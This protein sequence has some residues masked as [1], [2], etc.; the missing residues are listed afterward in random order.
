MKFT[1]EN[2]STDKPQVNILVVDD[3]EENLFSMEAILEK[4]GY[5]IVKA[6]SGK[7]ALKILL[8][9]YDFSLILM[10]VQM[11]ELNGFETAGLIY[12]RER[13]K[14]I[15]IIF[16]TANDHG[17]D[18]L[19]KGYR[20][21][22]V[23]YLF[24]PIDPDLLRAKV[25]VFADLY[26][27]KYQLMMQEQKLIMANKKLEQEVE[28]KRISEEKIQVLNNQLVENIDHLKAINEDLE[29][30]AYVASHDLQ[31]PLRKIIL[32]GDRLSGK[33]SDALGAEGVDYLNRMVK[34]TGRMQELIKNILSFSRATTNIDDLE[35]TDINVILDNIISD[36]E[37]SISQ[38]K[39]IIHIGR[40][41]HLNVIPSQIRQVF[42]N[43]IIN[44]LK[45]SK[46]DVPPVITISAEYVNGLDVEGAD[47][48]NA[49]KTYCRI[50]VKDNGIGFEQKYAG[51]VFLIFKRLHSHDQF[52]GTGI[53]LS[54]CKKIVE[55]HNG[56]ISVESIP[57][58][59]TTFTITLPVNIKAD[60]S[61]NAEF[62][63]IGSL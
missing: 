25:A 7:E 56:S 3:K 53:G 1:T 5:N 41:P 63:K 46:E 40:I 45:F 52:E 24:K 39:A 48:T 49:N 23:D 28:E 16:I 58:V 15:P 32:F 26:N 31:E 44:A 29:R 38:K 19:F 27:K 61:K 50:F 13:L 62:K 55:K 21:G 34:A 6:N 51:Q 43:L 10:D 18:S 22:G 57:N 8:K 11:P 14:H 12:E 30:F 17:A 2:I 35:E 36:L 4:D 59:G 60:S 54:I 37:V 20:L 47:T 42:Q 9:Q 33:Y